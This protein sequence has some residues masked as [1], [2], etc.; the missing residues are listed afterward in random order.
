MGKAYIKD[1][2]NPDGTK[3]WKYL[4]V[5]ER[6]ALAD[7]NN[8]GRDIVKFLAI[9]WPVVGAVGS[10]RGI[11]NWAPSPDS[12]SGGRVATYQTFLRS[13]SSTSVHFDVGWDGSAF[14]YISDP[15]RARAI[16][17]DSST[18]P[19][20]GLPGKNGVPWV[21]NVSIGIEVLNPI[22]TKSRSGRNRTSE[23]WK[24]AT[25][26]QPESKYS[27]WDGLVVIPKAG[28][29][30]N[31]S[32]RPIQFQP[33]E[34]LEAAWSLC[35][36]LM[37]DSEWQDQH[38]DEKGRATFRVAGGPFPKA[39]GSTTKL[40]FEYIVGY[41]GMPHMISFEN[42]WPDTRTRVKG[43]QIGG[44]FRWSTVKQDDYFTEYYI[45]LRLGRFDHNTGSRLPGHA[46][47]AAYELTRQ[48]FWR[49]THEPAN[50]PRYP[51]WK[52]SYLKTLK[53]NWGTPQGTG[54]GPSTAV[55]SSGW[56]KLFR[57]DW[58]KP[59]DPLPTLP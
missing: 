25:P 3:P 45:A 50:G 41:T 43:H 54:P 1:N 6:K 18:G 16:H 39:G 47:D 12:K 53:T 28:S 14:Q 40:E 20:A 55:N 15:W 10:R 4:H 36:T 42:P 13:E 31:Y 9:H 44:H 26:A 37:M 38:L 29:F 58:A 11:D 59:G 34:Q 30:F 2:I 22:F 8:N 24:S 27:D 23:P 33:K 19:L 52:A 35:H 56:P 5:A 17:G 21:N 48:L 32:Q 51:E 57:V 7:S 49:L 46:P